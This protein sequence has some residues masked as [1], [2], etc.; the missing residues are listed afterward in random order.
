VRE[1]LAIDRVGI[2]RQLYDETAQATVN[3]RTTPTN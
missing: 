1:A 2:A 3:V